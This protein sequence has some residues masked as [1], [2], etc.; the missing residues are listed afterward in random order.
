[1]CLLISAVIAD[2]L[3]RWRI[4]EFLHG[5]DGQSGLGEDGGEVDDGPSYI[6]AAIFFA[7]LVGLI[8]AFFLS[9]LLASRLS[10]PLADLTSAAHDIAAGESGRKVGLSKTTEIAE[11]GEAFNLL[12]DSLER[13]EELRRNMVADIAHEL[14]TPISTLSAQIEALEDGV[15]QPDRAAIDSLTEDV[16]LLSRLVEDL[17]QLTL[18][19]GG[20]LELDLAEVDA[21][22]LIRGAAARFEPELAGK[23]MRLETDVPAGLPAVHADQARVA[24]VLNNLV[25]NSITHAPEGGSLRMAAAASGDEVIFSVA[26]TGPGIAGEDLPYIF[27][28]FYRADHSRARD[29]GGA[30]LGLSIARSLVEAHGGRIWA[31]SAAGRGRRF[32]L[33][34]PYTFPRPSSEKR[35]Y[36][37]QAGRSAPHQA[38]VVVDA[39]GVPCGPRPVG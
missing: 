25:S 15:I 24:Q 33:L 29:T 2:G 28:R 4:R 34:Y 10:R 13:N 27:E 16:L 32:A 17:Q 21:E 18:A 6:D 8:L 22:E 23:G 35:G 19:D 20:Q 36:A 11:L 9:W 3:S 5:H 1:M 38:H 7:G 31:E 26:D 37:S 30:G 12:S 39:D 14:R